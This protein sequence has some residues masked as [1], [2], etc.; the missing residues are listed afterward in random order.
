M[1]L[2]LG[3]ILGGAAQAEPNLHE[4]SA[5]LVP[6]AHAPIAG[7]HHHAPMAA[8]SGRL[9]VKLPSSVPSVPHGR[10][11]TVASTAYCLR[12]YT[13]SGT[14]VGPGTIAVD[15]RV[16]PL[17]TRVYVS[18]YGYATARDTGGA[19]KGHKIDVWLPT[20]GQCYQWGY[21]TVTVTILDEPKGR[22]R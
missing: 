16:I 18:G 10:R 5:K 19:I 3:L 20:L 13:A 2:S 12:G 1:V 6:Q 8:R 17:G 7:R 21:R 15:P 4:S 9:S 22:R 14:Y 11:M